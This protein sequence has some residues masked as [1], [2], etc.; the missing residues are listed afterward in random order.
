[1]EILK[2]YNLY[3]NSSQASERIGSTMS[4]YMPHPIALN[5]IIPSEFQVY[6][7]RANIP[8]SF[9]SFSSLADN[10]SLTYIFYNGSISYPSTTITIS[11]G[12]YNI[13][14]IVN[15][16]I[17]ALT[18]SILSVSGAVVTFVS[19]YSF[20]TNHIRL[21]VNSTVYS[22]MTISVSYSKLTLAL[23]FSNSFIIPQGTVNFVES[24][25]DI[26]VSPSENLFITS[27]TL[28]QNQSFSA[29]LTPFSNT[30]I[31]TMIPLTLQPLNFIIHSPVNP[32][33]STLT[34]STISVLQ[35]TIRDNQTRVLV[36]F[37]LDWTLHL[38]I[39]EVRVHAFLKGDNVNQQSQSV[40]QTIQQLDTNHVNDNEPLIGIGNIFNLQGDNQPVDRHPKKDEKLDSYI[41]QLRQLKIYKKL[42]KSH[43]KNKD[44]ENV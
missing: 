9:S 38:V 34:N 43:H 12:N 15:D 7:D 29:I 37:V 14:N 21:Q 18:A 39:Q 32:I 26:N 13:I 25:Q 33:R 24:T 3:I 20:I 2:T 10:V 22:N 27:E 30:N 44:K 5:N 31:L 17:T 4:I 11:S 19:D 28:Q 36:D 8:Y 35:F 40:Q 1:M 41:E 23:G 42:K 16:I 6:I